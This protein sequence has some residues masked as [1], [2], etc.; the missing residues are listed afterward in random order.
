MLTSPALPA[1][2]FIK[3][4]AELSAGLSEEATRLLG[5]LE[6]LLWG[7]AGGTGLVQPGEEKAPER[8]YC[9]LPVP[10][11]LRGKLEKDTLLR[12]VMIGQGVMALE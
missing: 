4:K 2:T 7:Q 9:G 8:P 12:S 11:L 10:K 1:S 5:G 6:H 3:G